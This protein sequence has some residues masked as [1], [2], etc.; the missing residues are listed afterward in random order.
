MT[1]TKLIAAMVAALLLAPPVYAQAPAPASAGASATLDAVRT[2]G[3]L[4]CGIYGTVPG[5]SFVT[6]KGEMTG[7]DADMCRAVAAAVLGDAKKVQFV[8]LSGV[9]RFTALAVRRDRHAGAPD[10]LD[11]D[12]GV[13]PWPALRRRE[14][15]RRDGLY[16][17]LL[18]RCEGRRGLVEGDDMHRA[19]HQH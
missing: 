16:D 17:P 5:F 18:D 19:G 12:P 4:R 6:S 7:L 3:Q 14:L 1:I 10:D 2:R 8:S 11:D 9:T 15:L 13:Q